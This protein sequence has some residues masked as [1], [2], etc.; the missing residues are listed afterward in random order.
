MVTSNTYLYNPPAAD[1]V[2]NGF[3]RIQIR[4]PEMTDQHLTDAG[5]E[6]QL[7][8]VSVSNRNPNRYGMETPTVSLT[9]GVPTYN[10]PNRTILIGIVYMTVGTQPDSFDRPL[11]PISASDYGAIPNKTQQGPPSTYFL[12][13][14]PVPTITLWPTPDD[15]GPYVLNV[16][17]FRQQQDISLANGQNFDAPYRMLDAMA[18]G[19]AFR[20]ARIYKPELEAKR[21]ADWERAWQEFT[22]QDQENV[23]LNVIPGLSSYFR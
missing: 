19:M 11:G 12:S 8:M 4:P 1:L 15:G 13:L 2:L 10:L 17:S 21:E 14:L 5:T 3:S 6:A 7:L 18:A 20:L 22:A 16:Q 23:P 9:Q